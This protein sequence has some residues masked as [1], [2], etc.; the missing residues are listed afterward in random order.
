[1]SG[2][3]RA[4]VKSLGCWTDGNPRAIVTLEGRDISLDGHYTERDDPIRKCK[5]A[6]LFR[7]FNVFALQDGGMCA[8][9]ADAET[10]YQKYGESTACEDDGEGGPL[11]NQVYEVI[12]LP[13]QCQVDP[14]RTSSTMIPLTA[15]EIETI[16]LDAC[17]VK[18]S[19]IQSMDA[20]SSASS[21]STV[22]VSPT[23]R[24]ARSLHISEVDQ[25]KV[26]CL[27]RK[28]PVIFVCP[29]GMEVNNSASLSNSSTCFDADQ[30]KICID[31]DECKNEQNGCGFERKCHNTVGSYQ[32]LCRDNYF[33]MDGL[34]VPIQAVLDDTDHQHNN[35]NDGRDKHCSVSE[36]GLWKVTV[37]N[38]YSKWISCPIGSVGVMR[39]FCNA[40]GEWDEVDTTDCK[41]RKLLELAKKIA[42]ITSMADAVI[43]LDS[44][45]DVTEHLN[46]THGG[47]LLLE[48]DLMLNIATTV[49]SQELGESVL[50]V[51]N[52]YFQQFMDQ[53]DRLLAVNLEGV[54][55]QVHKEHGPNEG[56]LK[57]FSSLESFGDT[58]YDYMRI[59]RQDVTLSSGAFDF[60]GVFVKSLDK[61]MID[62]T[63]NT[64]PTERRLL[65]WNSSD[66]QD[67]YLQIPKATLEKI[68]VS[69]STA[70]PFVV[71]CYIY[72]N[73]GDILPADAVTTRP[74]RRQSVD[75]IT[76]VQKIRRVNTPVFYFSVYPKT[77]QNIDVEFQMRFYLK[78]EGY[79]PTCSF[80]SLG[81]SYGMW[82]NHGCSVSERGVDEDREYVGCK[83]NHM[84]TFAVITIMGKEPKPF[85]EAAANVILTICCALSLL[86]ILTGVFAIFMARLTSDFYVVLCQAILS[87]GFYPVLIAIEANLI[88]RE[89]E[90]TCRLVAAFS[91]FVLLS[92]ASWMMKMS[93][94]LF[95]RLKH[96]VYRSTVARISYII[97]GWIL[98][99]V[100]FA[101]LKAKF[102]DHREVN[103]CLVV[104]P[105]TD[106]IFTST[107]ASLIGMVTCSI[108]WCDYKMFVNLA[109]VI[110][111]PE[112]QL[113]WDKII[114]SILLHGIF[115]CGRGVNVIA[116]VTDGNPYP[117]YFLAFLIL[118]EG[119]FVF[120]GHFATNQEL[121]IVLRTRYF[122]LDEDRKQAL[123]DFEVEDAQ[124]LQIQKDAICKRRKRKQSF[125]E[126]R[127]TCSFVKVNLEVKKK[128]IHQLT[129]MGGNTNE[130]LV[131]EDTSD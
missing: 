109:K 67:S 105:S 55:A 38:H 56:V 126:T 106:Y 9:S 100:A 6:A 29:P 112:E 1:M 10:T 27:S 94:Q 8:S 102:P 3:L 19:A 74:Q 31:I 104:N 43:A 125:S 52:T 128:N 115:I 44:L 93:I 35:N 51:T 41:T 48:S 98:P 77:R 62:F 61:L 70:M 47:D 73:P 54:W 17:T 121:L 88:E 122:D 82:S 110:N 120:L 78:Q 42:N 80:M 21:S 76:A 89:N 87:L 91:H 101:I 86:F 127:P 14:N 65:K 129:N 96:Y 39:R 46:I 90:N 7:G 92:N 22:S 99:S 23:T 84:A 40:N 97:C 71:I 130:A 30:R 117:I 16:T 25:N 32:C 60:R 107:L 49:S 26:I 36:D 111:G 68:N 114:T 123:N 66:F 37:V 24:D 13:T 95:I 34:C 57:L 118:V 85:L 79:S 28:L 63:T 64:V 131:L 2:F 18:M 75:S 69:T 119:S 15:D 113:L 124:R 12:K 58:L 20:P 116:V 50:N 4:A 108:Y 5:E 72:R 53:I 59:S 81:T 11:A 33:D 83:C 103:S 45:T